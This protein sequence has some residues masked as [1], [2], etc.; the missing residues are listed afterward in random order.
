M[1]AAQNVRLRVACVVVIAESAVLV[2]ADGVEARGLAAVG[3][4]RAAL[5]EYARWLAAIS[6][7]VLALGLAVGWWIATRA[8]R[9]VEVIEA[10]ARRIARGELGE[11]IA[12]REKGSEL[13]RLATALNETFAQL[14]ESFARQSRF[15]ADAAHELGTP[16]AIILAQ[17]QRALTRERDSA[18]YQQTLET[19]VNAARRLHRITESLLELATHDADAAALKMEPCDLAD[20]V[21]DTA[22]LLP[23][24]AEE[25]NIALTLDLAAAPCR[26]DADRIAQVILNLLTNAIEH[27]PDGGRITLGARAENSHAIFTITDTGSGIAAAHLP[28]IFASTAPTIRATAAPAAPDS[29]LRFA[30]RS[31]RP[32]AARS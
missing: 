19:C 22:G 31:P 14:E 18:T 30:K 27:T 12:V 23:P 32:T 1:E 29:A 20:I 6:G 5:R 26:A 25:R 2:S 17:A 9:P 15:T 13:G 7:A 24:A 11:R 4:V 28:R 3:L 21:R 10:T 8:I 16:V